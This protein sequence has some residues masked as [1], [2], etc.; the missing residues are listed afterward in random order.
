MLSFLPWAVSALLSKIMCLWVFEFMFMSS[1]LF[2][3]Q[4]VCFISILSCFYTV[5]CNLS[6]IV[7]KSTTVSTFISQ[8]CFR[9]LGILD[10]FVYFS[11]KLKIFF[12]NFYDELWWKFDED[13]ILLIGWSFLQICYLHTHFLQSLNKHKPPLLC[14]G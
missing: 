1:I 9:V 13:C 2:L 7:I 10:F 14:L 8:C 4:Y 11:M 5:V 6:W 3:C 12:F